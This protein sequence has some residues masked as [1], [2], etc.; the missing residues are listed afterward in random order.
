MSLLFER[1][2]PAGDPVRV[3]IHRPLEN[4]TAHAEA[5]AAAITEDKPSTTYW[6]RVAESTT[7]GRY[8]T[9]IE[10]RVILKAEG[11]ARR[12]GNALDL[13]CGGGRWSQMLAARG[14]K[15]TCM[16]VSRPTL[17]V[18]KRKVGAANFILSSPE[19]RNL[20]VAS[21][22]ADLALC[23]EV[24]PLIEAD[25]FLPEVHRALSDRGLFVGVYINGQSL[26]G[27]AW[28]LKRR[29]LNGWD[30]TEFYRSSYS[31][32]RRHLLWVGF[33]M[34]HEESCCWGPF[35][36]DSNSPLVPACAKM[37][38][39]LRLNRVVTWSPWVVFIARKRP[40]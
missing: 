40:D 3:K 36:R 34:L 5:A 32:W 1:V 19:D 8:L 22:S 37:E 17:A 38:R 10:K 6:D 20:P 23:I 2:V 30:G 27:I 15:M 16:D 35:T 29:L 33:E 39:A 14:W 13:G 7:W 24:I 11:W 31:A 12:P 25:W 28:R 9:E 18:C 4:M 26:R 21:N